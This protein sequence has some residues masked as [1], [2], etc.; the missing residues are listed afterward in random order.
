M[1]VWRKL[2][3]RKC[4]SGENCTVHEIE[5]RKQ[6]PIHRNVTNVTLIGP[7]K[8]KHMFHSNSHMPILNQPLE[9]TEVTGTGDA[10]SFKHINASSPNKKNNSPGNDMMIGSLNLVSMPRIYFI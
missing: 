8:E 4:K 3:I 2:S 9:N 7:E 5:S 10:K 1:E 6:K